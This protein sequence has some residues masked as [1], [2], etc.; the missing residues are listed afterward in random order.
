MLRK[1]EAKNPDA[2][3]SWINDWDK[4][5]VIAIPDPICI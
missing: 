5:T 2:H 1:L 4:K 3:V